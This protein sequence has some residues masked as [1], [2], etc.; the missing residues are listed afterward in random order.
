MST[1]LTMSNELSWAII[2]FLQMPGLLDRSRLAVQ[3]YQFPMSTGRLN[4][5]AKFLVVAAAISSA[6][7]WCS[8]ASVCAVWVT[9]AGSLRLPRSACRSE[10]GGVGFDQDAV[11][12]HAGRHVAQG[13]RLGIGKIAGKRDQKTKIERA[14]RLLPTPAET[15]HY[16]AKAGGRPVFFEHFEK[17]VPGVGCAIFRPAMDEDRPLARGGDLEL[18][19]KP[20]ALNGMGRALVVIVQAD[21]AAGDDFRFG[22][23][24]IELGQRGV[25]G[26]GARCADRFRRL[27]RAGACRACH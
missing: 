19:D 17:I 7:T 23:Q 11:E 1:L 8:S 18:A 2:P 13:L 12:R 22:E 25:V 14:L 15:V 5:R 26:F 6:E 10:P 21:L 9:N 27:H 24:A 16:A 3:L 20:F 4:N